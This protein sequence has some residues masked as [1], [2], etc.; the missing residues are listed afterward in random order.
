MFTKFRRLF[1]AVILASLAGSFPFTGESTVLANP[2]NPFETQNAADPETP[3]IDNVG[4]MPLL[5]ELNKGQTDDAVKFVTRGGGYTMLLTEAE[6]VFSLKVPSQESGIDGRSKGSSTRDAAAGAVSDTLRM[7]FAGANQHPTIEGCDEAITKTNYYIGKKRFEGL[8]NYN[9][10][11]YKDLYTGI[12]AVFY[13]NKNNQLEYDFVVAP[14][15]DPNQIKLK[16][17]GALSVSHDDNGDLVVKTANTELVQQKPVVYQTIDGARREV[18]SRYVLSDG[19][20]VSFAFGEYDRSKELVIDPI[21]NYLTYIGGTAFDSVFEVAADAQGNAYI[22][23]ETASLNFH[24]EPRND[25]DGSAAYV[26]NINPQGTAFVYLTI[27]EG[28]DD[29]E[30]RGITVD[31][32]RNVYV[33]GVASRFFPTTSGA[34]DTT[35]GVLN[36]DD[37]FVAKLDQAGE[38]V[39]STFLGGTGDDE[40]F[41]VAID[42]SGK[43]Y[44]VGHTLSNVAFPTKNKYQG[45]GFV[46]PQSF[47]SIDAFLTVL[48]TAGSD[49]TYSTCIGGSVTGDQAFSV[50]LDQANN[51]YVTGLAKGGNFPTKNAF[52]PESGGGID[53]WVAKFNP[54]ASGEASLVYSTYLG[55]SGTDQG[56]AVAV[57]ASGQAHV[58]GLTGS[59]NF[60]LK[61]AFRSV[62]QINEGFVTVLNS[63]GTALVNSSFLGSADQ[64]EALNVALGTGGNIYITGSTLSNLFP[65]S[66]PFQS[67][68]AGG[69]DAFVTKVR[70]PMGVITSSFLGGS[71]NDFGDGIAVKGNFVY[72]AGR[73]GSTNLATTTGAIKGTSNNADG[74]VAKILDV[75]KDTIGTYDPTNTIFKLK[76][77]LTGGSPDLNVNRG[78]AGD[79]PVVGDFNGDGI[80]TASTFNNGLWKIRN[81]NLTILDGVIPP[82]TINFGGPGDI[83]VVGDWDGDGIDTVGIYRPSAGQFF[84]VNSL[85]ANP[86]VDLVQTFGVAEDLPIAGDWN[87]D[88]FDTIGVFRPSAG[89]FFLTDERVANPNIDE[90][91][92]LGANGD[93]PVGGDWDGDGADSVGLW[94]TS[95]AEFFLTNDLINVSN[96]FVFGAIGD[97]PLA[98]DWD[99]KPQP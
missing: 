58:V 15:A 80:D 88:G 29:D 51:A 99:G 39:Y 42:S 22:S 3:D 7:I 62:N 90:V 94:R 49:I 60:P 5:F 78:F 83:P 98:S 32:N 63:S 41:D 93:L 17:D 67:T 24:G 70:F 79:L 69:R 26:A 95:T 35:H 91:V 81:T 92:V 54:T 76:N 97:L 30:G 14:N 56:N 71:G 45:C 20:A 61:N 36:D 52:R 64:D 10:V 6:A 13:G 75:R 47:D 40:G 9:K 33:T 34:F 73:T 12:D 38:L 21:L 44:V 89:L 57:D 96:Q 1:S 74:F 23:G 46:F 31:A 77:T 86:P 72:F 19:N 65:T 27:L 4:G 55:G 16:F 66:L 59:V 82:I 2:A 18:L 48:N 11:V 84:L 8:P 50:A 87:A 28:N 68:R 25:N 37:V 85:I 43:A 53:A